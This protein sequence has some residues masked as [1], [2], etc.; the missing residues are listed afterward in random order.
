MAEARLLTAGE[1][2]E[3]LVRLTGWS[4]EDGKLHRVFTFADF[5]EAWG[6]MSAVALLAERMNHHPEWSNVYRT[7][8]IDLSTHDVGGL[9]GLD[10]EL[11]GRISALAG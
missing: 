3:A 7:V 6:F 2:D 9:S 1:I 5:V 8:T 4:L 11:A 10:V